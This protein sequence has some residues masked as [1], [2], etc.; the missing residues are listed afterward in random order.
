MKIQGVFKIA[1]VFVFGLSIFGCNSYRVLSQKELQLRMGN[2]FNSYLATRYL[3]YSKVKIEQGNQDK[4]E[5]FS[6]KGLDASKGKYTAPEN[7]NDWFLDIKDEDE[8]LRE[9]NRLLSLL[10]EQNKQDIPEHMATLQ[11]LYD[12]WMDQASTK[13][14]MSNIGNCRKQYYALND[15][16]EVY[17]TNLQNIEEKRRD[18]YK[19]KNIKNEF[20]VYFDFNSYEINEESSRVI[21]QAIQSIRSMQDDY[22][23]F[24]EGHTDR[25]GNSKYNKSLSQKRALTVKNKMIVN[26][27]LKDAIRIK[28][29]GEDNPKI[30]TEDGTKESNNRRVII[31]IQKVIIGDLIK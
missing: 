23:V 16:V 21:A 6:E 3:T 24:L 30:I 29:M 19:N 14:F 25:V 18:T 15:E 1:V 13:V 5:Y 27:I 2:D 10:N 31:R 11:F 20:E 17:L 7:V 22:I 8:L 26:G 12:C 28:S 4:S 9:R